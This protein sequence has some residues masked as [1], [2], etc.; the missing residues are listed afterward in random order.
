MTGIDY[1][2]IIFLA[3]VIIV[4]LGGFI[5]AVNKKE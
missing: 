1:F 4:G 2:E 3:I 5:L